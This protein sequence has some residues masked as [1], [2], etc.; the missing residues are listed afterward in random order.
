M[1][2]GR[3]M[4][5]RRLLQRRLP[6]RVAETSTKQ[7]PEQGLIALEKPRALT[8]TQKFVSIAMPSGVV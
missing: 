1:G 7:K 5:Q 3:G 2:R 4:R 6:Y 8:L